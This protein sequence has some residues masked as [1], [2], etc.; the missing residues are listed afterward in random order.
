MPNEELEDENAN[1]TKTIQ[2]SLAAYETLTQ[3]AEETGG[4]SFK[5]ILGE[6]IFWM[7]SQYDYKRRAIFGGLPVETGK[8]RAHIVLEQLAKGIISLPPENPANPATLSPVEVPSSDRL[9]E[10]FL[11][12]QEKNSASPVTSPAKPERQKKRA[13]AG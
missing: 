13:R 3:I 12:K 1:K 2:I 5:Q 6:T 7:K 9:K 11:K 8:Y 10:I 4:L